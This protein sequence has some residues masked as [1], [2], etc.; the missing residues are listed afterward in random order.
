MRSVLNASAGV[1]GEDRDGWGR[2]RW[3]DGNPKEKR[4]E[5]REERR[6]SRSSDS[7]GMTDPCARVYVRMQTHDETHQERD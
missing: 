6:R 4:E 5:R 1:G 7:C 3:R 2:W